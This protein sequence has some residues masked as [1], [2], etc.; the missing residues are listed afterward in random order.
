MTTPSTV[1][2]VTGKDTLTDASTVKVEFGV[3]VKPNWTAPLA[4]IAEPVRMG[5]DG[6]GKLMFNTAPVL[7]M[8]LTNTVAIAKPGGKLLTDVDVKEFV[9]QSMQNR[10]TVRPFSRLRNWTIG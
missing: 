5:A 10:N 1:Q 7:G 6:R 8:P 3:L 4:R 9:D 2:L